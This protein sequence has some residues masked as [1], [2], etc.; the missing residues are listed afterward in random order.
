MKTLSVAPDRP[1]DPITLEVLRSV[2]SA[3]REIGIPFFVSG[4][5]ARD[6][7]LVHAL[8]LEVEEVT[9]DLDLAV[10]VASWDQ[11]ATLKSRLVD[12]GLF[13]VAPKEAQRLIY[14]TGYRVD[15]VPFGAVMEP[16]GRVAWP[17]DQ[18]TVMNMSGHI[19]SLEAAWTVK[20]DADLTVKVAGPASIAALKI[21]AWLDRGDV[22]R[23]DARDITLLM[24]RYCKIV[25]DDV[26]YG[27]ELALM[28]RVD[29]VQER[30]GPMLLGKHVKKALSA[31]TVDQLLA[32]LSDARKRDRLM[33]HVAASIKSGDDPLG[34][35]DQMLSDF[36]AGLLS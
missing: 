21:F 13:A 2:D 6:I 4:A 3:V 19:E 27:E 35:A 33:L 22:T 11:F 31:T 34:Q 24:I 29:Y 9:Y 26:L 17:P 30:A 20:V 28:E 10:N 12:T 36:V 14:R 7:I 18:T 5:M 8:G 16:G 32:A 1:I 23:K 25:G 15:L